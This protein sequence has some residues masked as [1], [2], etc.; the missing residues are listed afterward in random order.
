MFI[1]SISTTSLFFAGVLGCFGELQPVTVE[2][3]QIEAFHRGSIIQNRDVEVGANL[4]KAYTGYVY[5]REAIDFRSYGVNGAGMLR[6]PCL[7][8]AATA[9]QPRYPRMPLY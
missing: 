2:L 7:H 1:C 4:V 9:A 3:F 6:T 5:S 8:L